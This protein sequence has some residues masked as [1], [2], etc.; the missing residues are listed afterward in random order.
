MNHQWLIW[1]S[2]IDP[3]RISDPNT[4][5]VVWTNLPE[6][7]GVFLLVGVV[8][9]AVYFIG[10]LYAHEMA[11]CSPKGR[12]VLTGIRVLVAVVLLVIFL[13]PELTYTDIE[14]SYPTLVVMRDDSRSM[15][16]HDLY[17]S[18]E[19]AE[20]VADVTGNGISGVRK[21]KP[22][23][24]ELVDRLL[25]KDDRRLISELE[26]KGELLSINFSNRVESAEARSIRGKNKG[27]EA[28]PAPSDDEDATL[29]ENK[30]TAEPVVP[31]SQLV[32]NGQGTDLLMAIEAGLKDTFTNAIVVFTDGQHTS[33]GAG[34]TDLRDAA[35]RAAKQGTPLFIVGV[36]DPDPPLNLAVSGLFAN[37]HVWQED[38]FAVRATIHLQDVPAQTLE[39]DL[40]ETPLG[41]DGK[42]SDKSQVVAHKS[43]KIEA[44][45]KQ[46]EVEFAHN[47]HRLGRFAYNIKV[48]AVEGESDQGDNQAKTAAI[49]NVHNKQARVL[50]IAGAPTW[51]YQAVQRLLEND[52]TINLSCWLQSMDDGRAQQGNTPLDHLPATQEELFKFDVIMMFDPNP[53]EFDDNWVTLV[54]DFVGRH[55]GGLLYMAG[56]KYAGRFLGSPST[57]AMSDLLPVKLGDVRETVVRSLLV[58]HTRAWPLGIVAANVDHYIMKLEDDTSRSMAT[59]QSMPGIFWTFPSEDPKPSAKVLIEQNAPTGTRPL[60]VTSHFG[61]GR[62]VFFGFN[63]TWRWRR[64][65]REAEFFE[66]FWMKTTHF[67]VEGKKVEGQSL[68]SVETNIRYELGDRITVTAELKT[69]QLDALDAVEVKAV[70]EGGEKPQDV[71]LKLVP[72]QPGLF[73]TTF[74]AKKTGRYTVRVVHPLDATNTANIESTYEVVLP[75]IETAQTWLDRPLL[76]ELAEASG[77]QYFE[78]NQMDELLDAIPEDEKKLPKVITPEPLWDSSPL[79]LILIGLLSLEWAMR[80]WFKLL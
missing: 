10:W 62:T 60:L 57:G 20:I 3:E 74:T 4:S 8:A 31:L 6:S 19:R 16:T 42:P 38:P 9:L 17:L 66:G 35:K 40:E 77:G 59:W 78:I 33:K 21:S 37:P 61:S 29:E 50:L 64:I 55:A 54:K 71:V 73:E 36:G 53:Q 65:G 14:I 51:E 5:E 23:R 30:D 58:T 80:K 15:N 45:T 11:S 48:I 79:F 13:G 63:G 67:L 47:L 27:D 72:N 24:I 75:S 1:L 22:T 7:L 32:A 76:V 43:I 70:V 49:V 28:A 2:G 41:K 44:D 26:K 46:L 52:K 39:I 18:D 34:K 56:P 25:E 12:V 68:G 69:L